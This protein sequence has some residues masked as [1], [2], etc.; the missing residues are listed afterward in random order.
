MEGDKLPITERVP[1]G[2][3]LLQ[4][5]YKGSVPAALEERTDLTPETVGYFVRHGLNVMPG[6]RKTELSDGDLKALSAY[7]TRK[8][9]APTGGKN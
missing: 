8:R 3:N 6:F 5:R 4:Q 1:L 2:T 9:D 7:L